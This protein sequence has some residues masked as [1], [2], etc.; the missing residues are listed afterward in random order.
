MSNFSA[1]H[2]A[3]TTH[4]HSINNDVVRKCVDFRGNDWTE[5]DGT[6]RGGKDCRTWKTDFG[7]ICE[8]RCAH[9]RI[10]RVQGAALIHF[11]NG[12]INWKYLVLISQF[13]RPPSTSCWTKARYPWL[14][15]PHP[16][17]SS[18]VR[19]SPFQPVNFCWMT[20]SM[21]LLRNMT[22]ITLKLEQCHFLVIKSISKFNFDI[23]LTITP[24]TCL[25]FR[26]I[27]KLC[28]IYETCGNLID[29]AGT[30][31]SSRAMQR[32]NQGGHR[33]WI[34]PFMGE[35]I[36]STGWPYYFTHPVFKMI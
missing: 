2:A 31:L 11:H 6:N 21:Y 17:R 14:L 16:G 24:S 7:R 32:R 23:V 25:R 18:S 8:S 29:L 30:I 3:M 36:L 19:P 26:I 13:C 33:V 28:G 4:M 35:P 5:Q 34:L 10:S 15:V 12:Y 27:T 1:V 20:L 9:P 22:Q